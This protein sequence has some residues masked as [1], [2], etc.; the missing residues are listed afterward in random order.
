[1][2]SKLRNVVMIALLGL[3]ML[4]AMRNNDLQ[5]KQMEEQAK[6]ERERAALDSARSALAREREEAVLRA[7][8][9]VAAPADSVSA[10]SA[11]APA[12]V[13]R[14]VVVETGRFWATFDSRG[15][16]L[17]SLRM[18]ALKSVEDGSWPELLQYA[19]RGALA[20]EIDGTD[21]SGK[22]FSVAGDSLPDTL[23]V[24]DTLR[25]SFSW[26]DGR[27]SVERVFAFSK[28]GD[29]F[30]QELKTSGFRDGD[31]LLRW[32][33]GLRETEKVAENSGILANYFFSEVVLDEDYSVARETPS[34]RAVYNE[35]QGHLRWVGLRRKYVAGVVRF[36]EPSEF[37]VTAVEMKPAE[38]DFSKPTWQLLVRERLDES[39]RFDFAFDV[40]PL[41]YARIKAKELGYEKILVSGWEWCGADVWF[42]GLT[43][44][45]LRLLN[46]F[47]RLLG[48]YGLA[49]VLLTLLVRFATLPLTLKQMRSMRQMQAHQ[50]A[51]AEIRKKYRDDPRKMQL[52]TMEYYRK[53]GINPLA[54]MAGCFPMLLQMPVFIALFF[55]LGR[56]VE[57]REAPFALWIRDLSMPDIV[58]NA[59]HIPFVM[60]MGICVLPF[61]MAL[62]TFFQTRQTMTD[63]NQRM[64]VYV[65]PL[66]MFG[67]A[68][69]MPSGL[70]LYWIVSNLFGIVQYMVIGSPAKAAA[71]AKAGTGAAARAAAIDVTSTARSTKRRRK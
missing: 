70:V 28:D 31:V 53:A 29:G 41:E 34:G 7:D 11:A 61:V 4:W 57:L 30:A 50:P 62:T 12:P 45:L 59:V 9:A 6:L 51:L 17:S 67:F 55:V 35:S 21:L 69:M 1:M 15:A 43:G 42:V 23:V 44:L 64:M 32:D 40:F 37:K 46:F 10:D 22:D 39:G 47:Y 14:S 18:K 20:L 38:G 60:P 66:M 2:S 16:M 49:I 58:T 63:P 24:G 71:A 26:S 56:S 48:N 36:A 13:R 33:A 68:G 8:S 52:E 54:Q 65:M 5:Q 3:L 27:R 25:L 19:D